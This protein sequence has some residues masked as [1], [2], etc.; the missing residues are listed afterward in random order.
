MLFR[1][2]PREDSQVMNY[3][4]N[5]PS[6]YLSYQKRLLTEGLPSRINTVASYLL[7]CET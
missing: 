5:A 3:P 6:P 2:H 1:F 7:L 4:S